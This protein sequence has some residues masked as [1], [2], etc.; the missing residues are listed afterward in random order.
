MLLYIVR[1]GETE[2][3]AKGLLQGKS[4]G[5]LNKKGVEQARLTGL[6]LRNKDITAIHSS[7]LDRALDTA[8][9]I[10]DLIGAVLIPENQLRERNLGNLEV[11]SWDDYSQAQQ[12]SG[13]SHE[14]FKPEGGESLVEMRIRLK[15]FLDEITGPYQRSNLLIVG[16]NALNSVLLDMLTDLTLAE[17]F[18]KGQNNAC[19]NIL[20]VNA[21]MKADVVQINDVSHLQELEEV[22]EDSSEK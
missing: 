11:K 14:E 15:P 12:A 5:I 8:L 13:Q 19:I 9:V 18:E 4:G 10:S 22:I 6:A 1:H 17:I 20:N 16:H 7:N 21:P 3:N 2:Q